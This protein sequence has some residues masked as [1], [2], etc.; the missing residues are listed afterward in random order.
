MARKQWKKFC[1]GGRI[2][3][4]A[5]HLQ[6]DVFFLILKNTFYVSKKNRNL[7]NNRTMNFIYESLKLKSNS[8]S[9]VV[10]IKVK[11]KRVIALI[12]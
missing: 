7:S 8:E 1:I 5:M 3:H 12:L 10:L 4:Y 6:G 2:K 11:I 9:F